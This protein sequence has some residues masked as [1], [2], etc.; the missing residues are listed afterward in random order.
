MLRLSEMQTRS[1]LARPESGMGYQVVVATMKDNATRRG[2]AYNAELLLFD[3]EP[4][5]GLFFKA[6]EILLREARNS[7]GE[8]KSLSLVTRSAAPKAV[9]E[10]SALET[11]SAAP[12]GDAPVEATKPREVFKRFSAYQNDHRVLPDRSL[13][14]G[15]YA[16]TEADAGKVRTGAEAVERYALPEPKPAS[17]VFTVKPHPATPIQ[18]GTVAP[19]YG[20]LGGGDEVIF[21]NGTRPA[22]VTGPD[23]IPDK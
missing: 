18:R 15:T 4:R 8:V 23:K 5:A 10:K 17:H 22:T 2:V 13:R 12:A 14:P 19:A 20:H 1:L 16:T 9:H 21:T 6:H 3:N 7:E 11:R